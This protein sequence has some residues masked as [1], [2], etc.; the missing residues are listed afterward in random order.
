MKTTQK[1]FAALESLLI[2]VIIA[3]LGGTGYY[4]WNTQKQVDKTDAY[5]QRISQSTPP[6]TGTRSKTGITEEARAIVAAIADYCKSTDPSVN[7][8][9]LEAAL[10]KQY[11]AADG[12]Q[13][14]TT[15]DDYARASMT[16]NEKS[17]GGAA[18]FLRKIDGKWSVKYVTQQEMACDKVD[19]QGWPSGIIATCY[20]TAT[21]A[22]RSPK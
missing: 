3:I 17:Q 21:Q 15:S 13:F 5:T 16:C 12:G 6:T 10:L 18:A 4:V 20:D 19:G 1:G 8:D 2:L 22:D 11:T 7:K 9:S 14:L